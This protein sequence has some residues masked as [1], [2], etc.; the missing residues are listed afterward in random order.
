MG[1]TDRE[2]LSPPS[3]LRD[4]IATLEFG[5]GTESCPTA[6]A[7]GRVLTERVDAPIDVP[8][9]DR[10]GMDGYA[11]RAMETG[12]AGTEN[13]VTLDLVGRIRAGEHPDIEVGPGD[14]AEITTGAVVPPGAD[15]V[16]I[17]ERTEEGD[18]C[19]S[20]HE[21]VAPG[22]NV[23]PA[24]S[25]IAAGSRALGP[26]TRL[27][28]REIGLLSALGHAEVAVR[29]RPKVGIV[30]TGAEL[31]DPGDAVEHGA[32]EIYDANSNTIAAA[33]REAGGDPSVHSRVGDDTE[34][35]EA[36]LLRA[37]GECDLVLSSGSTSAGAGDVVRRVIEA[38]GEL[39]IHGVAVKPGKPTLVGRLGGAGY[40]G[41]PG[42]PVSALSIFRVFVAPAIRE[43]AGVPEPAAGTVEATMA[44]A[45]RFT[46]ER[47]RY[48]PVGLV[49]A[50]SG[51]TLAYPVD[52]GSGATTSL[53][54]ADGVVE[55][56]ADRA[57]FAAGEHVSVEL[58]TGE[59]GPPPLLGIGEDDPALRRLLDRIDGARYLPH[60][61][62]EG[63]RLLREG[64]PDVAVVSGTE[65]SESGAS[66]PGVGGAGG[67]RADAVDLGGWTREWGLV[68]PAGNPA[69]I[70]G[71]SDLLDRDLAL[72]NRGP[73]SGLRA[74]L[75]DAVVD[76][77]AERGIDR[78]DVVAGIE[79]FDRGFPGVESPARR[80]EDGRAD[81]G[82][83]LHA[84]AER[85]GLGFVGLGAEEVGV[86]ASADRTDKAGV[87]ALRDALGS[88]EEIVADL[89]GMAVG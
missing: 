46:G 36:V 74:S 89:P 32:G 21:S 48:V 40:V 24:G 11:V 56:A 76:V 38:E 72:A 42:Y 18:G 54:Y 50:G 51:G 55:M 20:V 6:R 30:P 2:D 29:S 37:A 80:V 62:R 10:A 1:L 19:V 61:S 83:G 25:D 7:S 5:V 70:D 26:G 57:E 82:L 17:V 52:K 47:H 41:L 43:A 58:L 75:G 34:D 67:D 69:G 68:V 86:V 88:I 49:T 79:G 78:H 22:E 44:V 63:L 59:S 16:V 66:G 13:P 23:A 71:L 31:V 14:A 53:A 28:P 27:S 35:M 12:G 39:L 45:E 84:T 8:G 87:T 81:A 4:A 33:V 73:E 77:A 9:F 64:V 60:G 15:A 65:G 85:L 3:A